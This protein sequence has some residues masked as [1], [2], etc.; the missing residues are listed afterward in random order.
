MQADNPAI[1]IA[2]NQ[3][4]AKTAPYLGNALA[5]ISGSFVTTA[6]SKM[7]IA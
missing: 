7:R 3:S 4:S 2:Y 1:S 5:S 6:L